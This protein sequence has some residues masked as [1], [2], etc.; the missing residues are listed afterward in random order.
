MSTRTYHR[1]PSYRYHVTGVQRLRIRNLARDAVLIVLAGTWLA[2]IL[3]S[4]L[5]RWW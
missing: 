1:H 3:T 5:W 4:P 2:A